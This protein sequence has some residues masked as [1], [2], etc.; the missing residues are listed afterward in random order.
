M[1]RILRRLMTH[2]RGSVMVEYTVV[3][4]LVGIASIPVLLEI[5]TALAGDF[6]LARSYVLGPVP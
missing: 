3:L 1:A 6:D 5:G 4:L 2:Q